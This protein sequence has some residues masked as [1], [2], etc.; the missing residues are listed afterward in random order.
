V[1]ILI[2]CH[3]DAFKI[4]RSSSSSWYWAEYSSFTVASSA[5]FYKLTVS[6]FV[7]GDA[8]DGLLNPSFIAN[9]KV[10]QTYDYIPQN[11]CG[12]WV[13]ATNKNGG[14][15]YACCTSSLLNADGTG[16]WA[17]ASMAPNGVIVSDITSSRLFAELI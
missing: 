2:N 8:G 17:S 3:D 16:S 4:Q 14:W 15:W 13:C 11:Y 10:F 7:S 12:G 5:N 9:G 6:S 1:V